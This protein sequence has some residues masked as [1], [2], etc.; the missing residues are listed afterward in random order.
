MKTTEYKQFIIVQHNNGKTDI[1]NKL[2]GKWR[3]VKS[4][5]AGKWRITNWHTKANKIKM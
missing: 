1:V 2:T 3:V 5:Q 4:N